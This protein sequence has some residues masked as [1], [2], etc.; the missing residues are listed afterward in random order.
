[1]C[2]DCGVVASGGVVTW[3]KEPGPLPIV[4]T[5][6]APGSEG[7]ASGPPPKYGKSIIDWI[8]ELEEKENEKDQQD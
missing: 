2:L 7:Y 8:R 6:G 1:M 4:Q 3:I 5:P